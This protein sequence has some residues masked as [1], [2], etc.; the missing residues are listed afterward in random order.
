[1]AKHVIATATDGLSAW[2][3]RWGITVQ[4]KDQRCPDCWFAGRSR[5]HRCSNLDHFCG[6]EM[7]RAFDHVYPVTRQRDDEPGYLLMPYGLSGEAAVDLAN[8]CTKRSCHYQVIGDG[9]H[10]PA[11]VAIVIFKDGHRWMPRDWD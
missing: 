11:T 1:M 8:W 3:R 7:G 9:F 2:E 10:H 4:A 6:D 5:R